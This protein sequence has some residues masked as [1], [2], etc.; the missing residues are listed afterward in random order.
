M[1]SV[2]ALYHREALLKHYPEEQFIKSYGRVP[3]F[4]DVT[5]K[6]CLDYF[7]WRRSLNIVELGTSRSFTDG[8]YAGCCNPDPMYWEPYNLDKWDWSAGMFTK[9]FMECL[10]ERNPGIKAKLTTL[11]ISKDAIDI[12]RHMTKENKQLINY[13]VTTS[14]EYLNS[15]KAKSIDLLYVDTGNMD[16]ETALLHLREAKLIV[17]KDLLKD[18]GLILIDDVRNP[19]NEF[20]SQGLGKSKYS[21][22][23]LLDHGYE[24]VVDEYQVIMRKSKSHNRD[25]C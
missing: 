3:Q 12:A 20:S 6:H 5:F 9:C 22:P 16:E 24:T 1:E 10:M 23:Y 7:E 8:K 21:I 19:C 13:L 11:D 17:E 25:H 18:D 4:R 2:Y 15:C 14:E